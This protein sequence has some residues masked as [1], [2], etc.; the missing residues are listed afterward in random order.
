[1]LFRSMGNPKQKK[2]KGKFSKQNKAKIKKLLEAKVSLLEA[3]V[4]LKDELL[5]FMQ[6]NRPF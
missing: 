4:L 6:S 3:E 2:K 1:M 5:D